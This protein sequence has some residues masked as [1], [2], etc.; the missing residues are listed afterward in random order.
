MTVKQAIKELSK[1]PSEMEIFMA[2]RESDFGFG[3]L[4]S[5]Y[6]KEIGFYEDSYDSKELAKETVIILDEQ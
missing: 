4:N 2:A 1:F 5:I 6:T 3:L